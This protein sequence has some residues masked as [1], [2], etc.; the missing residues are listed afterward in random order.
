MTAF[1]MRPYFSTEMHDIRGA[2]VMRARRIKDLR[3]TGRDYTAD[4]DALGALSDEYE[5]AAARWDGSEAQLAG[6]AAMGAAH[7]VATN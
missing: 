4:L 3:A 2:M 6:Y 7:N 1:D 5:A